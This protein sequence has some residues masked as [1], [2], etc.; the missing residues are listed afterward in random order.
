MPTKSAKRIVKF[1][2][3][4]GVS[5]TRTNSKGW[6]CFE[7]SGQP[8]ILINPSLDERAEKFIQVKVQKSLGITTQRDESKRNPEQIKARQAAERERLAEQIE[9]HEAEIDDLV[10]QISSRMDGLGA[11]LSAKD[12]R[13][14]ESLIEQREREVREWQRLMTEIPTPNA[15]SGRVKA[16]HRS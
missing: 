4:N 11:Q 15:H 7:A 12:I 14:I 3:A 1:L 13:R 2:E 5:Y 8:E 9:R 6:D 10:R 16:R